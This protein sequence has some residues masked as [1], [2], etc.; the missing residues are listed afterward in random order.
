MDSGDWAAVL[1]GGGLEQWQIELEEDRA[2]EAEQGDRKGRCAGS[3]QRERLA[4]QMK[5][6]AGNEKR[7][8]I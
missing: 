4:L 8:T 2:W 6:E 3:L 7:D 1:V 5:E